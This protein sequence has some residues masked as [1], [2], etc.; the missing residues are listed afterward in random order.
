MSPHRNL[1]GHVNKPE[2]SRHGLEI[3]LAFVHLDF[4]QSVVVAA[5]GSFLLVDGREFLV[6]GVVWRRNVMRKENRISDQMAQTDH[7]ADL[8][9]L[10]CLAW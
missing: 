1:G 5:A 7:I 8:D 4:E 9:A 6:G 2:V 3:A 10:V